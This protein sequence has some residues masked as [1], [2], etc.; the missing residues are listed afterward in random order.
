MFKKKKNE[1]Q[2]PDNVKRMVPLLLDMNSKLTGDL[3]LETDVRIDGIIEG[4]VTTSGSLIVGERGGLKGHVKAGSLTVYGRFDGNALVDGMT[5][6]GKAG[7]FTGRLISEFVSLEE[8]G[9]LNAL[10]VMNTGDVPIEVAEL[11]A[12]TPNVRLKRPAVVVSD[13]PVHQ[14]DSFLLDNLSSN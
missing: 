6:I 8:G 14:E 7:I 11:P 1:N 13:K 10:V 2:K 5:Q 9:E 3:I 4:N 12:F